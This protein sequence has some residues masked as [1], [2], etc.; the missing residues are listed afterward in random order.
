M[1]FNLREREGYAAAIVEHVDGRLPVIVGVAS[2]ATRDAVRLCRHAQGVGAAAVA[3]KTP[4][5]WTLTEREVAGHFASIAT[6]ID[7]PILVYNVP[8]YAGTNISNSLLVS[9]AKEHPNILGIIDTVDSVEVLRSRV[10]TMRQVNP[11]FCVLTGTESQFLTVLELGGNGAVPAMSNLAP[12]L[13][14]GVF[15]AFRTGDYEAAIGLFRQLAS[16][17]D[18]YTVSGSFHSVI[19]EAM[20]TLGLAEDATVRAPALPLTP[21]SRANLRDVLARAGL[22]ATVGQE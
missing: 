6:A 20:V 3:V 15:E 13:L 11:A 1:H 14:V 2:T 19:K 21:E 5:F 7:I 22:M 12:A 18:I 9:M 8:A 4:Y 10:D 16:G 17:L